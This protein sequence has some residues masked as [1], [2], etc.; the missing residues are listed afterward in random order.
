MSNTPMVMN[1]EL[2]K[3]L[4]RIHIVVHSIMTLHMNN[5]S[6][7]YSFA[8]SYTHTPK[9]TPF[10]IAV[11]HF[12]VALFLRASLEMSSFSDLFCSCCMSKKLKNQPISFDPHH[13][14]THTNAHTLPPT[15]SHTHILISCHVRHLC[16]HMIC[17]FVQ[18]TH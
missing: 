18:Q 6:L 3:K 15:L 14:S 8:Y 16:F 10:V 4:H 2:W 17:L 11:T 12:A 7:S 5:L 9:H 1:T 13:H